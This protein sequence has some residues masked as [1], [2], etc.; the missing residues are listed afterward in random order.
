MMT[1]SGKE[2]VFT[3]RIKVIHFSA[4]SIKIFWNAILLN[5]QKA[6]SQAETIVYCLSELSFLFYLPVLPCSSV[7]RSRSRFNLSYI[8]VG[9]ILSIREVSRIL[10]HCFI[11]FLYFFNSF[12]SI[13]YFSFETF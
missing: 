12:F 13:E 5:H 7:P 10:K 4:V 11:M 6:H 2:V 9:A 1:H 8:V 3:I